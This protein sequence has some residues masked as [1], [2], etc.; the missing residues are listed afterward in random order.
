MFRVAGVLIG[1]LAVAALLWIAGEMHY[2]NC[3]EAAEALPAEVP[4]PIFGPGS[5][6][7]PAKPRQD[8]IAKCS[9]VPF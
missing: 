4:P 8:A 1:L 9:R 7:P 6:Q 3:I 2:R 5:D